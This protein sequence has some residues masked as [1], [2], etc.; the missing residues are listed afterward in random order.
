MVEQ[1]LTS[2]FFLSLCTTM[3]VVVE[4]SFQG[5]LPKLFVQIIFQKVGYFDVTFAN[6]LSGIGDGG[7]HSLS[8][9]AAPRS[10]LSSLSR[11]SHTLTINAH[12]LV[13]SQLVTDGLHNEKTGHALVLTKWNFAALV[14]SRVVRLDIRHKIRDSCQIALPN[15]PAMEGVMVPHHH[16]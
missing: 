9:L 12:K 2:T 15:V 6:K 16:G 1:D 8:T 4:M 13:T 7:C 3:N 10:F 11:R 14:G 5:Q